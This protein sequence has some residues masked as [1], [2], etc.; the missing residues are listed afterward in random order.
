MGKGVIQFDQAPPLI[1]TLP[2]P[3]VISRW[4]ILALGRLRMS[5]RE[6][7]L[8]LEEKSHCRVVLYR[9]TISRSHLATARVL[10]SRQTPC[11]IL[12]NAFPHLHH[13]R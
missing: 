8:Y 12:R 9:Y 7:M 4:M 2:T 10:S 5:C 11:S 13:Q 1:K 3:P 6:S